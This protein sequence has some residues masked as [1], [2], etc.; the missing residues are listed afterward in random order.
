M[1]IP[2]ATTSAYRILAFNATAHADMLFTLPGMCSFNLW[3]GLPSPT[4]ANATHWFS[5][6]D[7]A[8]QRKIIQTLEAHPRAALIVQT[9]HIAYLQE[10]GFTPKGILYDYLQENFA[11]VFRVDDFEFHLRR[12]RVAA[13][14]FTAELLQRAEGAAESGTPAAAL[15]IP[16]A[17]PPGTVIDR[18][19]IARMDDQTAPP[20][21]FEAASTRVELAPINSAGAHQG[22]P[23]LA[24]FPLKLEGPSLLSLYFDTPPA[25]LTL[26]HTLLV[27]RAPDGAEIALVRLRP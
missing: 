22:A 5:L 2:D 9:Q 26:R 13:P 18:I 14:F 23:V 20:A 24:R 7:E 15:R 17:L 1:R 3:T 10:K 4:L 12:G 6:L 16:L 27:L 8:R 25:P 19:E 21:V 11:R